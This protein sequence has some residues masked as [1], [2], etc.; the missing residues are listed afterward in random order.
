MAKQLFL[1][2]QRI[3]SALLPEP[4]LSWL[5]SAAATGDTRD[6]TRI[7]STASTAAAR[8]AS[9]VEWVT[10]TMGLATRGPTTYP[11]PKHIA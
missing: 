5:A 11:T 2:R 6:A 7:E 9:V 3:E 10:A 8:K 4:P 1:M